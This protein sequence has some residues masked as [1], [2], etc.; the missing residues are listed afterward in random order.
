MYGDK[1]KNNYE[2]KELSIGLIFDSDPFELKIDTTLEDLKQYFNINIFTP[3]IFLTFLPWL[4]VW[5]CKFRKCDLIKY[6]EID[7]SLKHSYNK[8]KDLYKQ[9][10]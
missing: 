2:T 4:I 9:Y 10:P 3:F 5:L 8:L 7:D 1:N 6:W